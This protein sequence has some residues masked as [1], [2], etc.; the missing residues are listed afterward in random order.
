MTNKQAIKFGKSQLDVFSGTM[1]EF[2][3][4]A[5]RAIENEEKLMRAYREQAKYYE[6]K[7]HEIK[8]I[9]CFEPGNRHALEGKVMAVIDEGKK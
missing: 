6:D 7:L 3:K 4:L 1:S 9:M 8:C 2:I 5:I